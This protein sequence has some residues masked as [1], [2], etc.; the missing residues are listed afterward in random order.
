VRRRQHDPD[1]DLPVVRSISRIRGARA[2]VEAHLAGEGGAQP[3]FES[4]QIDHV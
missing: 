4:L 3:R 1:G 2:F